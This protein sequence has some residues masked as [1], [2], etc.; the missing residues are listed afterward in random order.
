MCTHCL[1]RHRRS[2]PSTW[3]T[4]GCPASNN[5]SPRLAEK[6]KLSDCHMGPGLLHHFVINS[7]VKL[8]INEG[9]KSAHFDLV[10]VQ[11]LQ[12]GGTATGRGFSSENPGGYPFWTVALLLSELSV[13]VVA[14]AEKLWLSPHLTRHTSL[15]R[16]R[17]A[18]EDPQCL[19]P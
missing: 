17:A 9:S 1:C 11:L 13:N 15:E 4:H 5:W 6:D 12:Q 19:S 8:N 18:P 3:G 7:A 10:P 2:F 16:P 14:K